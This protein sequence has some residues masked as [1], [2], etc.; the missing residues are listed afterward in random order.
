[1]SVVRSVDDPS[2][3][4]ELVTVLRGGGSSP[5][6]RKGSNLYLFAEV[7]DVMERKLY[8]V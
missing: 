1:M 7:F 4:N 5:S 3:P 8:Q 2:N 6:S